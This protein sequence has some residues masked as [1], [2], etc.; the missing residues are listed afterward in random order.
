[1]ENV[2]DPSLLRREGELSKLPK[3]QER[4]VRDVPLIRTRS[5]IEAQDRVEVTVP[6]GDSEAMII[7]RVARSLLAGL[8]VCDQRVESNLRH[9]ATS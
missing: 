9:A 2:V 4:A 1:M 6:V 5:R 8:H 7:D 3:L